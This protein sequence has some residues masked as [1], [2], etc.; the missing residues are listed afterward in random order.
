VPEQ[1]CL[2]GYDDLPSSAVLSPALTTVRQPRY[3]FGRAAAEL[4][5]AEGRPEHRHQEL[6]FEPELVVRD[7]TA[8]PRTG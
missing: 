3:E 4:L 8:P 2:V 1:I 7:S 5:P 6:R